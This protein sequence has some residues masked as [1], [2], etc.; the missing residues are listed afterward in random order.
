MINE[1]KTIAKTDITNFKKFVKLADYSLMDNLRADPD[2]TRDGN[3][4]RRRQVFSGQFV[5]V[6][7]TPLQVP[8]YV[9]PSRSFFA[10]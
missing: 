8:E 3:D 7:T 6:T 4:H 2:S 5:Q 1:A 9:S 10:E